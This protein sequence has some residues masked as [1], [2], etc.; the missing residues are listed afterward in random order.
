M[1]QL[2]ENHTVYVTTPIPEMLVNVPDFM[3]NRMLGQNDFSDYKT[4]LSDHY[5]RNKYALNLL[6]KTKEV[7]GINLLETEEYLCS[8]GRC[9]GS[10]DGRPIY[11]DGDHLSEF[12]NK[13][14][15]PMFKNLLSKE[16]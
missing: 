11:F 5:L 9:N 6:Q 8:N 4:L 10:I 13:Q 3:S 15:S 2:T 12:G 16:E 1:C 7:C 14:L